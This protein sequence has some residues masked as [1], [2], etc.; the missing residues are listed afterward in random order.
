MRVGYL[1]SDIFP[2]NKLLCDDAGPA[3]ANEYG[4]TACT[5][6]NV[7]SHNLDCVVVDNRHHTATDHERLRSFLSSNTASLILL[8]IND[9]YIFHKNDGWYKFC[10]ELLDSPRIHLLT[11]YQPTGLVSHW[12]S[13]CTRTQFVYAPFTYD[14]DRESPIQHRD[15]NRLVAI[16]G[17]QRK[18]LYPLRHKI[19]RASRLPF[20]R[21]LGQ[22][23]RLPHPGYPEKVLRQ[24]HSIT[25]SSYLRW[26]A[27]FTAAFVDSSVYRVELLKY[28]E[29][30]YAGCAPI[31]DLPWSL[32][33]CPSEA[34]FEFRSLL[35]LIGFRS[36]LSDCSASQHAA[37]AYRSF[38]RATRCR[39]TWRA[40]VAAS[41]ARLI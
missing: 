25:G 9:P 29:I 11:P 8:R 28:R 20:S 14:S 37:I 24:F 1:L 4:W 21:L 15:R 3:I 6:D 5:A 32:N 19:Q 13:L 17:N 27:Q 33:E 31:G 16:S 36:I 34:F 30:A 18:D 40:N 12:L 38:M 41:I 22:I 2:Y 10:S 35:D 39:E 7:T 26:L 23:I